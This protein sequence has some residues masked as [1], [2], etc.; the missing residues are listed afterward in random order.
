MDEQGLIAWAVD[1][2]RTHPNVSIPIGVL[3]A[4]WVL[5]RI[6]WTP[7]LL[8]TVTRAFYRHGADGKGFGSFLASVLVLPVAVME[9]PASPLQALCGIRPRRRK[10]D[11]ELVNAHREIR[12]LREEIRDMRNN[13][14]RA[15]AEADKRLRNVEDRVSDNK[16]PGVQIDLGQTRLDA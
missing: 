12:D 5:A 10:I 8:W 2:A 15:L 16:W 11:P 6:R 13:G 9:A 14:R 1:L 3:A 4:S 7:E